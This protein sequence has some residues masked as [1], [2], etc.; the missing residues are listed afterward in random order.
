MARDSAQIDRENGDR[1][2]LVSFVELLDSLRARPVPIPAIKDMQRDGAGLIVD[3]Y[4]CVGS[5]SC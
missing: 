5:S 4:P 3:E 1:Y 2:F